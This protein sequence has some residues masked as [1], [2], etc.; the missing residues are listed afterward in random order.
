MEHV[1]HTSAVYNVDSHPHNPSHVAASSVDRHNVAAETVGG[2]HFG[3]RGAGIVHQKNKRE[4]P[5]HHQDSPTEGVHEK[6]E[7]AIPVLPLPVAA[8]CNHT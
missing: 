6:P 8:I 4:E 7:L 5:A 2:R 3:G 1:N